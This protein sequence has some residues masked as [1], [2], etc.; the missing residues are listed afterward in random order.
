GFRGEDVTSNVRTIGSIPLRLEGNH[1]GEVEIRGEV[2][3]L[4]SDFEM[5]NRAQRDRAEKEFA[6]PRNAAAGSIRQLDSRI[7]AKRRLSFFAY[8][9]FFEGG[10]TGTQS[11]LMDTL[12]DWRI[13][14]S[15]DRMV[16]KGVPGLLGYFRY[17]QQKRSALP[18]AIDGVVYKVNSLEL[19]EA[20]GYVSRA[21]RFAVAHKFPPEEALT[22][23]LDIDV[24]VGRTGALTPVARLKPVSVGGV[25]VSNATLHNQDEI[26]R[27]DVRIGDTVI[28]RRAGDVIPEIVGVVFEKRAP[29]SK[30][31]DLLS[32]YPVCPVCGSHVMRLEGDAQARCTGG[33][34][35]SAQRREAI[36]HFA[37]RR[38]MDIDGLG[39][40]LVDQL[41]EKNMVKT[42][43][44]IYRL[45]REE[46]A[47]LERM[48][49]K[50]AENLLD[51]IDSSR[52]TTLSRFIYALG[53]RHVGEST[54]KD[55]AG[56]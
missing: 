14:V 13:P 22:E 11:G 42:P 45:R 54:A 24:Q 53:I 29:G 46:L 32:K 52:N 23:L 3:M 41:V 26:D 43:A 21:P 8:G 44:D 49:E 55:L 34:Y 6:N 51:A 16:V 50:S 5:L 39:E 17:M 19:Q 20:M 40:K 30:P 9:A 37:S 48:G 10:T 33:L 31:F 35:C 28:V 25:M 12:Q 18:F 38:A 56:H 4:K 27:K 1:P 36:L 15:K 2:L 7:T 47:G